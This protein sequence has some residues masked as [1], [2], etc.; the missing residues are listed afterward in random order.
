MTGTQYIPILHEC[1]S[2]ERKL[3]GIILDK[4]LSQ[5]CSTD[6]RK[7]ERFIVHEKS[8]EENESES[9][10]KSINTNNEKYTID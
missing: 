3:K 7:S 6:E 4:N 1:N 5:V 9:V 2:H 8:T 10:H